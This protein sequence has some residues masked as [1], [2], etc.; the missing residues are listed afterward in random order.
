MAGG[1]RDRD[2][3]AAAVR[4]DL[5]DLASRSWRFA[6]Y[7]LSGI[8]DVVF[9]TI[10]A[11]LQWLAKDLVGRF[12]LEG[13]DQAFLVVYQVVFAVVTFVPVLA[14]VVVDFFSVYQRV[15]HELKTRQ[16]RR[17]ANPTTA[18]TAPRRRT[19]ERRR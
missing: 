16:R 2:R 15:R 19:E 3:A 9:L 18:Q 1:P 14:Y 17:L 12:P 5:G 4:A 13:L 11:A 6:F 10:W 8:I 7:A